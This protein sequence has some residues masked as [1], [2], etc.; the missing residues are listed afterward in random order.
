MLGRRLKTATYTFIGILKVCYGLRDPFNTTAY[1][2]YTKKS[3][4][5][6]KNETTYT[7]FIWQCASLNIFIKEVYTQRLTYSN[8]R[9]WN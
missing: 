6:W 8:I 4:N 9:N 3:I 5:I 7:V 2:K 1:M